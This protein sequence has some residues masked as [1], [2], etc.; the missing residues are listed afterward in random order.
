MLEQHVVPFHNLSL[1]LDVF[2]FYRLDV[3]SLVPS[4][5]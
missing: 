1:Y 2:T 5:K 3:L 4:H